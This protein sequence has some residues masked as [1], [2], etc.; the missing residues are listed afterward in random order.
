M[1]EQNSLSTSI[2][3][4]RGWGTKLDFQAGRKVPTQFSGLSFDQ[5]W[6][7][8]IERFNHMSNE[9]KWSMGYW[10]EQQAIRRGANMGFVVGLILGFIVTSIWISLIK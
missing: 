4:L 8:D 7:D 6:H 10:I 3:K 5:A 2:Q 1:S 9:E